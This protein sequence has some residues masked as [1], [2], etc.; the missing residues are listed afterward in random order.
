MTSKITL[1]TYNEMIVSERRFSEITPFYICRKKGSVFI[2]N[3]KDNS[4]HFTWDIMRPNKYVEYCTIKNS[5]YHSFTYS[6]FEELSEQLNKQY[7]CSFHANCW[8]KADCSAD[9]IT[10][11]IDKCSICLREEQMHMMEETECGHFFC[12]GCLDKYVK[13]RLKYTDD[14]NLSE[15]VVEDCIPCPVCRR[16]IKLCQ[17]CEH[18]NFDC[19]CK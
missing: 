6:S 14:E 2:E 11:E 9:R 16:D 4:F 13:S 12:L 1:K 17:D 5:D 3:N 18:A 10:S 8:V 19:I 7:I 15:E